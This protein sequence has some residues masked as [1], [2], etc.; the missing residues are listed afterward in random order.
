MTARA[1]WDGDREKRLRILQELSELKQMSKTLR[2]RSMR[3]FMER[4]ATLRLEA[5]IRRPALAD[6]P[7]DV[8]A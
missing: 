5:A 2:T 8:A 1:K 4:A 7:R 3:S 6:K